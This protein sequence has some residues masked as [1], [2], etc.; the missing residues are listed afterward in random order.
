MLQGPDDDPGISK[1]ALLELFEETKARKP[2]WQFTISVSM[3][4]IYNEMIR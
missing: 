4:E 2:D 1:R 3:L